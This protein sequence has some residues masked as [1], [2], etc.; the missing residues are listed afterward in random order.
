MNLRKNLTQQLVFRGIGA[1]ISITAIVLSFLGK[2]PILLFYTNWSVWFA[3]IML[4]IACVG[5]LLAKVKKD[6]RL[7][8]NN[9][10]KML[11]FA[12]VIMIFATF[13]ISAFVLPEK[14]WTAGYWTLGSIFKHFLLPII[15]VL[16]AVLLDKKASYKLYYSFTALVAP[17]LYWI[18]VIAR[19]LIHRAI[20]GGPI[21][22]TDWWL[23]YPYGF[24]NIDKSA[25]LG[26][27]IGL[28][29]GILVALIG[30]GIGLFFLNRGRKQKA[31]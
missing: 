4:L 24:T 19:F 21:P 7:L 29:S 5:T 6:E 27:L 16:D 18:V 13:V 26:G 17:L 3:G 31:E 2:Q 8:D 15:A 28:L 25:S 9:I 1:I 11:K 12:S 14:I 10:Y 20:I 22:E 23:Y 30:I